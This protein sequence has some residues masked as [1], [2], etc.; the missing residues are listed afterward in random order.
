MIILSPEHLAFILSFLL[1][2]VL[3]ALNIVISDLSESFPYS[4][5]ARGSVQRT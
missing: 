1:A 4:G 2:L 5:A 3:L